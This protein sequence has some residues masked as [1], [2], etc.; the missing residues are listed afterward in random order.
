MRDVLCDDRKKS[1]GEKMELMR[2]RG[3]SGECRSEK[4]S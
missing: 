4:V 2:V 3:C 1:V